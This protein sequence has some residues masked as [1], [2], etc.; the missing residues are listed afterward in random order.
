MS[1]WQNAAVLIAL[2]AAVAVLYALSRLYGGYAPWFLFGAVGCLAFYETGAWLTLP[3]R[4]TVTRDLPAQR[5]PAGEDVQIGL[6]VRIGG[7]R[8][9]PVEWLRVEEHLPPRLAV[10]SDVPRWVAHPG[11]ARE[12]RVRYTLRAVPR[13]VYTLRAVAVTGGDMFGLLC[14]RVTVPVSHVLIVYPQPQRLI[15]WPEL[16]RA[17]AGARVMPTSTTDDASRVVG[18]RDYVPG[19]RLS[20]IHWPATA[21]TGTLRAKEFERFAGR[22][23][24]LALDATV[25]SLGTDPHALEHALAIVATLAEYAHRQG[26]PVG[27]AALTDRLEEYPASRGDLPFIRILDHLAGIEPR[28]WETFGREPRHFLR[29]SRES[30]VVLT[31]GALEESLTRCAVLTRERGQRVQVL[32][33]GVDEKPAG[34]PEWAAESALLSLGWQVTRVRGAEDLVRVWGRRITHAF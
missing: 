6:T 8:I 10:R 23:L 22:E 7:W 19:D 13:G 11:R 24:V 9:W 26:I 31:T 5:A 32:A 25:P 21:R 30:T 17:G 27:Y 18:V 12:I 20:R 2:Y 34:A 14:V 33:V 16:D 28:G 29:F 3:R 15:K 1:R 4:Y